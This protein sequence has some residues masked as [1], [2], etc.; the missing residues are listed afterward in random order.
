MKIY[1][2]GDV[3]IKEIR[4]LPKN[5]IKAKNNVLMMGE[6][7]NHSHRLKLEQI[8]MFKDGEQKYLSLE[9]DTELIHEEHDTINLDKGN[10]IILQER[11]FDP[12]AD[13]IRQVMD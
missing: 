12:F 10:Y 8:Q 1:R 6:A 11:E 3:L 5:I 7:T 9:Q 4:T 2:H 13:E